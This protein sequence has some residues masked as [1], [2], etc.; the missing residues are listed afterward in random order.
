MQTH[1]TLLSNS[2]KTM[3]I[4][5]WNPKML[6]LKREKETN[7]PFKQI[8]F[9]KPLAGT[10]A[11]S[12]LHTHA[13]PPYLG[14]T[15]MLANIHCLIATHDVYRAQKYQISPFKVS[16]FKNSRLKSRSHAVREQFDKKLSITCCRSRVIRFIRLQF[17]WTGARCVIPG[18]WPLTNLSINF[19]FCLFNSSARSCKVSLFVGAAAH[20]AG[21]APLNEQLTWSRPLVWDR[22]PFR[23]KPS[24]YLS[25]WFGRSF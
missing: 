15:E 6:S 16:R 20:A 14:C 10:L 3:R 2:G 22:C 4:D 11:C 18:L 24:T 5:F 13:K 12:H 9:S 25:T 1:R 8:A 21:R 7:Y 17:M 19:N 23:S